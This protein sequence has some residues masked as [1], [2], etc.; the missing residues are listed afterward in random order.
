MTRAIRH[1]SVVAVQVW[2][3]QADALSSCACV[4]AAGRRGGAQIPDR[5]AVHVLWL[6]ADAAA[7]ETVRHRVELSHQRLLVAL[8]ALDAGL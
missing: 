3:L 7:L 4:V 6:Q 1:I 5:V 8:G 2:W